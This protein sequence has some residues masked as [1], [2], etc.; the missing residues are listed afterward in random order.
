MDNI[1]SVVQSVE[2]SIVQIENITV[3]LKLMSQAMPNVTKQVEE[4][5]KSM[6][7]LKKSSTDTFI[8]MEDKF[9]NLITMSQRTESSD[10]E[11]TN[12][13]SNKTKE[14]T[15]WEAPVVVPPP[16]PPPPPP[17]AD[18]P[19][20]KEDNGMGI[21]KAIK[22]MPEELEN[23][24]TQYDNII[25]SATTFGNIVKD[26]ADKIFVQTGAA[27]FLIDK[28]PLIG[29]AYNALQ[30][31]IQ[32]VMLTIGEVGGTVGEFAENFHQGVDFA[33]ELAGGIKDAYSAAEGGLQ[34]F[35]SY[36]N[37][38]KEIDTMVRT[39]TD[40][41]KW[42]AFFTEIY[43]VAQS[44][45]NV[46]MNLSPWTLVIGFILGLVAALK[47]AWDKSESFRQVLFG[48]WEVAKVVFKGLFDIGK[49]LFDAYILMWKGIA[50]VILGALNAPFDGGELYRK[51][52][53]DIAQST[54]LLT[55]IPDKMKQMGE[56]VGKAWEEGKAKGS[57]S[58]KK[59][60]DEKA[61]L[62]VPE[63]PKTGGEGGMVNTK[64][65]T[66]NKQGAHTASGTNN[67][68]NITVRIESLVKEI[69]IFSNVKE[70]AQ[71]VRRLV[72]E[73]LIAAVR[74]FEGAMA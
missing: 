58:Y 41:Q 27:Q 19:K 14:E 17:P 61:L 59:S 13:S 31:P 25:K 12:S 23:L 3:E 74:D 56:D 73:E 70:G 22:D 67:S 15:K 65:I 42:A 48:I 10:F 8:T 43:T 30:E 69:N 24:R 47:L 53:D 9:G 45:L 49:T 35:S 29:D 28:V 34:S 57:E 66:G 6:T 11:E 63:A 55:G 72:Q 4:L 52:M 5:T 39:L 71:D 51:G 32:G 38:V 21:G 18:P 60:Q 44:A 64:T 37:T 1:I 50:E 16:L 36:M 68:R 40:A 26:G 2:A 7:K 20:K 46:V 62:T 33:A 54:E